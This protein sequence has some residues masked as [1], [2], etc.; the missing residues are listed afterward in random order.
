MTTC[1][2][3]V[4]TGF[5]VFL[6]LYYAINPAHTFWPFCIAA[7]LHEGGHI[8]ALIGQ[9]RPIRS[10]CFMSSGTVIQVGDLSYR[11]EL[12]V[13]LAGP[14]VNGLLFF[15]TIR[16]MPAFALMNLGL[17]C[18]NMLPL[19]P[20]DGGRLLRAFLQIILPTDIALHL[21]KGIGATCLMLLTGL[22]VY[23]TC[24]L[25]AGLWPVL[26]CAFLILRVGGTISSIS[27][28]L[29]DKQGIP[30]YNKQANSERC[31]SGLRSRS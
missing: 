21:E 25:H 20:L 19:Y 18:Y 1:R 4:R 30:C 2:I 15:A 9:G 17:F 3:E 7:A 27:N 14:L 10:I 28:F 23:L 24:G 29:L 13:S 11:Q 12:M 6:A 16:C 22:S 26:V 5:L 31:P 8:L